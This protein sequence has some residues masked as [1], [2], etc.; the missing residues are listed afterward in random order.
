MSS[1]KTRVTEVKDYLMAL[2]DE[3]CG[4]IE[5]ADGKATF[6]REEIEIDNG[7]LSRPRII[8]D[9]EGEFAVE[10]LDGLL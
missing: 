7:G 8:N 1:D 3:I 9:G 5:K 6:S 2:Q 10:I 4:A